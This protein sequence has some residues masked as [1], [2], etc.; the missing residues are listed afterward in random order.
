MQAWGPTSGRAQIRCRPEDF[1]VS[2][3]LGFELSGDGEHCFLYLEK[4]QLNTL[5]LQQRLSALSNIAPNRIGFS[6]L[7]DRNAVTRQW[8][9]VGLAGLGEPDWQLL[10]S[11]G[12]VQVLDVG[13]HRRHRRQKHAC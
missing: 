5:E 12:D 10:E 4:R 8:F 1:Q 11:E 3:Q 13:R 2:E 9:S 6:G 7:K